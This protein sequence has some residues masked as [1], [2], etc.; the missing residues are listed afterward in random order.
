MFDL[1]WTEG[2]EAWKWRHN[3]WAWEEELLVECRSLL[4]IVVLQV[5]VED[6]W[7]WLPD[8][9]RGYTVKGAYC[10]LISDM[11]LI[12][13]APQVSADLLCRKDVS[14]KVSVFA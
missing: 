6:T 13:N 11:S 5:D 14:L 4:L 3:L 9:G 7:T 8:P 1:G 2:G 12:P 10:T